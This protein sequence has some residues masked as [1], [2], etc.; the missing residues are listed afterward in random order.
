L[1]VRA[2][3]LKREKPEEDDA[4]KRAREEQEILSSI[5]VRQRARRAL[6]SPR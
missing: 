1:L 4:A 5:T 3:E 2:A 6:A